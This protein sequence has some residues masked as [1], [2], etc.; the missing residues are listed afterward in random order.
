MPI[1]NPIHPAVEAS[2]FFAESEPSGLLTPGRAISKPSWGCKVPC[3]SGELH[4]SLF[5]GIQENRGKGENRTKAYKY[6]QGVSVERA[7]RQE[8][9]RL[10]GPFPA[11][12][13]AFTSTKWG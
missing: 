4:I 1:M 13:S 6:C 5:T 3:R 11:L 2:G 7:Q 9:K 8:S 10:V 12:T